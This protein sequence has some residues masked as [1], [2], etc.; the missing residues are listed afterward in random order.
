MDSPENVPGCVGYAT[1]HDFDVC[2][3]P[4]DAISAS[5]TY[6]ILTGCSCMGTYML[7]HDKVEC[8]VG[9][10]NAGSCKDHCTS[11]PQDTTNPKREVVRVIFVLKVT[12]K[13]QLE[14]Q[15][16][17]NVQ[18]TAT[19]IWYGMGVRSETMSII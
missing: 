18:T 19:T 4:N 16:V 9:T 13:T 2:Y 15:N 11:C 3:D 1:Q 6:K 17:R 14:K 5:H 8:P 10:F 12:T 7:N